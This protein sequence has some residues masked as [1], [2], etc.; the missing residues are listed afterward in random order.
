M[1]IGNLLFTL[2]DNDEQHKVSLW[3]K[4]KNAIVALSLHMAWESWLEESKYGWKMGQVQATN[5]LEHH[6]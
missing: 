4:S 6:E 5:Q 3:A 2:V 1:K